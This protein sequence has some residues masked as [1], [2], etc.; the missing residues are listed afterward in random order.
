MEQKSGSQLKMKLS[1]ASYFLQKNCRRD[2]KKIP[3]KVKK[4]IKQK[5][6]YHKSGSLNNQVISEYNSFIELI[7]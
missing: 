6:V 3:L 2:K 7:I 5:R 4:Q 1:I